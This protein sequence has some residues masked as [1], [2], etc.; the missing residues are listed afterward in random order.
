MEQ[1]FENR[2]EEALRGLPPD[3]IREVADFAEYL[4]QK[5]V[6]DTPRRGS[7]EAILR[8]LEDVGPLDFEPGELDRRLSEIQAMREMEIETDD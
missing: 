7:P 4:R 8:A 6:G 5:C 3:K 1:S 2:L